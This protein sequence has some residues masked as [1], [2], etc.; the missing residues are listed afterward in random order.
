M[1]WYLFEP[2]KASCKDAI[3]RE[4]DA[5]VADRKKLADPK[6]QV[7]PSEVNRLYLPMVVSLGP[8]KT[9]RGASY[10]DYQRLFAGGVVKD[11]V[12][13]S[14]VVGLLDE[15][16]D[17]PLRKDSGYA[18]WLTTLDAVFKA[19]P[20][21]TLVDVRDV[22]GAPLDKDVSSY[23]L[24]SGKPVTGLTFEDFIAWELRGTRFPTGLTTAEKA[25]LRTQVGQRVGQKWLTFERPIQVSIAGGPVHDAAEQILTFFGSND[26]TAPFVYAFKNS[27]VFV[28]NGHSFLGM[29]PLD[30]DN[31]TTDSFPPSYQ[32]LFIDS[33]V[34]YNYY[35]KD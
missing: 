15:N 30:P 28:Y 7:T 2:S 35:E 10:P 22:A 34:S 26:D 3:K 11:K 33:C 23:T 16:T 18:E 29:G 25:D 5:I 24:K 8:D 31:Y 13:V 14:L 9:N 20:G 32:I 17:V 19:Q 4:S 21:F 12:V 1:L 6:T 27:D